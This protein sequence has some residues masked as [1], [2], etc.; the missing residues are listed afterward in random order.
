MNSKAAGFTLVELMVV[1]AIF[2]ILTA[3]AVP[4]VSAWLASHRLSS[5][6]R[7]VYSMLQLSR[8][9]AVKENANVCISFNSTGYMSFVDSGV[10]GGGESDGVQNGTEPTVYS[11]TYEIGVSFAGITVPQ[12]WYSTRGFPS[13][14][15]GTTLTIQN[16]EGKRKVITLSSV[17]RVTI[18]D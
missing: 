13:S 17:G 14:P 3:I 6:A 4:N 16:Q 18:T 2:A 1:I 8:L 15:F 7:D 9:K 12:L 5:S 11:G 10:G